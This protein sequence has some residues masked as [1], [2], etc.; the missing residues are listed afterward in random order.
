MSK[1]RAE[2]GTH[3]MLKK[4]QLR[5]GATAQCCASKWVC[6]DLCEGW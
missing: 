2:H 5:R 4:C 3:E 6:A 1:S